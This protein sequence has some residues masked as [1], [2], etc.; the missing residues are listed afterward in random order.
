MLFGETLF[1]KEKSFLTVTFVHKII[2]LYPHW[3]II[4]KL[5]TFFEENKYQWKK[6]FS[7]R[8]FF[9][10]S[11]ALCNLIDNNVIGKSL[12]EKK[13]QDIFFFWKTNFSIA[14]INLVY[15]IDILYPT[16]QIFFCENVYLRKKTR[17]NLFFFFFHRSSLSPLRALSFR[18]TFTEKAFLK[19]ILSEKYNFYLLPCVPP[20]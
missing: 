8:W 1:S 4:P 9:F 5:P 7:K 2:S 3:W 6:N 10:L 16:P 15:S 17:Q 14:I 13:T 11:P 19:N 20:W 12:H 18:K